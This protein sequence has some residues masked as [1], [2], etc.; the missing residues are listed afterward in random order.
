M[1]IGPEDS[2]APVANSR[3]PLLPLEATPVDRVASPLDP[4]PA[5]SL[6]DRVNDPDPVDTPAP[7]AI[8]TLPPMPVEEEL[9]PA[10]ISTDPPLPAVVAPAYIDTLPEDPPLEEPDDI[11]KEPLGPALLSPLPRLK[12]PVLSSPDPLPIATGPEDPL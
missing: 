2:L 7:E 10:R 5:A 3:P 11:T 4:P 9:D 6:E 1:L 12:E 8:L